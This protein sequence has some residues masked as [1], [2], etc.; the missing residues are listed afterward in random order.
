MPTL[1]HWLDNPVPK[2][3]DGKIRLGMFADGSEPASRDP[4]FIQPIDQGEAGSVHDNG[5]IE[6]RLENLGYL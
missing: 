2:D 4:V 6:D 5:T 1:L 3:V